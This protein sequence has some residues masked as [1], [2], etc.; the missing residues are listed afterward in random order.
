MPDELN[1]AA[2]GRPLPVWPARGPRRLA[3]SDRMRHRRSSQPF[4]QAAM[5]TSRL[6]RTAVS[7]HCCCLTCAATLSGGSTISRLIT[8]ATTSLSTPRAAGSITAGRLS[9]PEACPLSVLTNRTLRV[10]LCPDPEQ[11]LLRPSLVILILQPAAA[12]QRSTWCIVTRLLSGVAG[13]P[14]PGRRI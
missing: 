10:L 11:F 8:V 6:S 7:G 13:R 3:A 5:A 1:R 2:C 4:R 12:S 14:G 9:M